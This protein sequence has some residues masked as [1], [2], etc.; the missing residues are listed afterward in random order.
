MYNNCYSLARV[1]AAV[2]AT[3]PISTN[4]LISIFSWQIFADKNTAKRPILFGST[5]ISEN[6]PRKY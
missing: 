3:I 2:V 5:F 4:L 6:L 1:W